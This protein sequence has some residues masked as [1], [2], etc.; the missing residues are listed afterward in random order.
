MPIVLAGLVAVVVGVGVGVGWG[1]Y[2]AVLSVALVIAV[3]SFYSERGLLYVL[4]IVPFCE[5]LGVG[6]MSI[7]RIMAVVAALVLL[8]KF[9]GGRL[10]V[11]PLPN[12]SW[13]PAT[14]FTLVIVSSGLWATNFSAWTFALGQVALA[15][16]YFAAFAFLVREPGHIVGILR[17]YVVGAVASAGLAFYEAA[18]GLRAEAL[19]GDPNIFGLYQVAALPAAAALARST[20]GGGRLL[21]VLA[22]LPILGSIFASQSRGAL[23]AL[24]ATALVLALHHRRRRLLVPL[25]A[26]ASLLVYMLAPLIDDRYAAERVSTDRASGRIDIWFTAWQAFL[27]QP[28]TGIGAGNYVSQSIERLT[29]EPGVQLIKSHLL[30]GQGIEVHNIYLEALAERGLFGLLTLLVLLGSALWCLRL[31]ARRF[32]H[33]AVTAL[34]PMLVAYC[35]ASAFLSVS[36]S[37]LLWMLIG[38]AAALLAIPSDRAAGPLPIH[39]LRSSR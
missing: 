5:S 35:V 38:L 39:A 32:P 3:A 7:G 1:L 15:I 16:V 36:N 20:H 10:L 13:L 21:W 17:V 24:A 26:G 29:T 27:D 22:S 4:A 18:V 34:E 14:A 28:L 19:Q 11:R 12:V 2:V 9:V 23:L 31:A 30:T 25:V 37:K 8:T 6:P 33:P